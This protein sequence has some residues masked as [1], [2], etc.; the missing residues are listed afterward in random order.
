[1]VITSKVARVMDIVLKARKSENNYLERE[2]NN[3]FNDI[4]LFPYLIIY[5]IQIT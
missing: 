5:L 2:K 4:S 3:F 1:M